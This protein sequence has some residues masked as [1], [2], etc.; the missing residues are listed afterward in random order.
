ML[1]LLLAAALSAPSCANPSIVSATVKSVTTSGALK[2][3]TVAVDVQNRGDVA[4]PSDLLMS[5][6][7]FQA[8]ARVDQIGL[9]PLR[10]NQS[11]TVTYTFHRAAEAGDGTTDLKFMLDANGRAGNDVDCHAG[12]ELLTLSV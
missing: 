7:V 9:Q 10:P 11:Q 3:Y 8:G 4:Q 1:A 2:N 6:D 12:S 5:V